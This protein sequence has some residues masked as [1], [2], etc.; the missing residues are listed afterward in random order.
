MDGTHRIITAVR[1]TGADAEDS[2]QVAELLD[3]QPLRSKFFCADSHYGIARIYEEVRRRGI[4]LIIPRRAPQSRR[5]SHKRDKSNPL[6]ARTVAL[7]TWREAN[8]LAYVE[9][10]NCT[11]ELDL[12]VGQRDSAVAV[13]LERRHQMSET[14]T[15]SVIAACHQRPDFVI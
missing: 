4:R 12:L 10:D 11:A 9:L 14:V 2:S 6:D 7:W 13:T 1:V 3:Q 8:S 15:K 5:K